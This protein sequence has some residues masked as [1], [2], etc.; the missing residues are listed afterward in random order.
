M[1]LQ[2]ASRVVGGVWGTS[3]GR[4]LIG[5]I[6]LKIAGRKNPGDYAVIAVGLTKM[7]EEEEDPGTRREGGEEG[8][9]LRGLRNQQL[10]GDH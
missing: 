2:V 4:D 8:S 9:F 3:V 10:C 6:A 5:G 1:S 7:M